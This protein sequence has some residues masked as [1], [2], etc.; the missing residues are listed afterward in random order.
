MAT[1]AVILATI[2][3]GTMA[4][5]QDSQELPIYKVPNLAGGEPVN[6]DKETSRP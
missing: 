4:A 5:A 2:P 3:I 6:A 1:T